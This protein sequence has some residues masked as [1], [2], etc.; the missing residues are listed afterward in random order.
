MMYFSKKS[1]IL[2][3]LLALAMVLSVALGVAP[4]QNDQCEYWASIGEC[5]KVSSGPT[6]LG[7]LCRDDQHDL[8]DTLLHFWLSMLWHSYD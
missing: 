3:K 4:D 2:M 1:M 8:T 7:F 6:N 5:N